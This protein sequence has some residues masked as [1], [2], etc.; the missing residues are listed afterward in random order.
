MVKRMDCSGS[1]GFWTG[2][3]LRILIL[4]LAVALNSPNS[5]SYKQKIRDSVLLLEIV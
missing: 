4:W 3:D 5:C 2:V 1:M